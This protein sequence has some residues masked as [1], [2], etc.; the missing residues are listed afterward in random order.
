LQQKLSNLDAVAFVDRQ[1]DDS[2]RCVGADVDQAL[3]LNLARRRDDRLEIA[4][5]DALGRDQLAG[6]FL[7]YRF[8]ATTAA[9]ISTTAAAIRMF[10]RDI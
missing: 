9:P 4:G 1:I 2:P 8:A 7:K 3:R 10:F 5:L 6:S